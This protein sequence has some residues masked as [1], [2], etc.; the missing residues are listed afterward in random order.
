MRNPADPANSRTGA[1]ETSAPKRVR[2]G[3]VAL[4]VLIG[5]LVVL[6]AACQTRFAI[7]Q[8]FASGRV[9]FAHPSAWSPDSSATACGNVPEVVCVATVT[10]RTAIVIMYFVRSPA[11][12]GPS[13]DEFA[14]D[15][16]DSLVQRY[17]GIVVRTHVSDETVDGYEARLYFGSLHRSEASLTSPDQY[18]RV[19]VIRTGADEYLI[20][21]ADAVYVS[22]TA[23]TELLRSI[24]VELPENTDGSA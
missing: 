10:D 1:L 5:L 6:T 7:T 12:L 23:V 20:A 11:F 3:L 21:Q 15:Y 18:I 13:T 22:V 16:W 8:R 2:Y 9:S 17:A 14:S 24:E 19:A 4:M